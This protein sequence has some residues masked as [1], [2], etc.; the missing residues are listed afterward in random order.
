MRCWQAAS[1]TRATRRGQR[2]CGQEIKR[3]PRSAPPPACSP[4][5]NSPCCFPLAGLC[6]V[7]RKKKVES[8]PRRQNQATRAVRV[9]Y[10]VLQARLVR[11]EEPSQSLALAAL[12]REIV[13]A[14]ARAGTAAAA[15]PPRQLCIHTTANAAHPTSVATRPAPGT[16]AAGAP[17]LPPPP[18]QWDLS[19]TRSLRVRLLRGGDGVACAVPK[20]SRPMRT[21]RR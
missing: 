13:T 1:G 17:L 21:C 20:Y 6:G 15:L 16:G 5:C 4:P 10:D 3:L 18:L 11:E 19:Y 14:G 12:A 7:C 9:A 2:A 8:A